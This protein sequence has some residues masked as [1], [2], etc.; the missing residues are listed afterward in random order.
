[1]S[2]QWPPLGTTEIAM[3]LQY[4]EQEREENCTEP[5]V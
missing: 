5:W 1:M 3:M 4:V 2:S